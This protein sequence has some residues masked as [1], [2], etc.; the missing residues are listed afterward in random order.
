MKKQSSQ[1]IEVPISPMID[2]IFLMIFFFVISSMYEVSSNENIDLV[3]VSNIKP[4]KI[5]PRK[6]YISIDNTGMTTVNGIVV[7]DETQLKRSVINSMK[8][9][10]QA[11]QFIVR[12]DKNSKHEYV[13]K[14]LT[15]LKESGA[16]NILLSG[17][18]KDK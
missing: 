2:I 18:R 14:F 13:D 3:K 8:A 11:T 10:G 7:N 16:H 15:K 4:G 5:S 6:V 9:W 1:K 12:A 17:E